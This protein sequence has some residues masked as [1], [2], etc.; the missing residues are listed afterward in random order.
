[1]KKTKIIRLTLDV[2][3]GSRLPFSFVGLAPIQLSEARAAAR[4]GWIAG[5]EQSA[6]FVK[7][8]V[9]MTADYIRR[10]EDAKFEEAFAALEC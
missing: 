6:T 3:D 1:M 7:D 9:E 5:I 8:A 2:T 10:K 4:A